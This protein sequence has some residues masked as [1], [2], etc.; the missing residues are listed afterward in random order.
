MC[1]PWPF[2]PL[3]GPEGVGPEGPAWAGQGVTWLCVQP[4]PGL[5]PRAWFAELGP[6]IYHLELVAFGQRSDQRPGAMDSIPDK[7]SALKVMA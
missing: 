1:R 2:A 4:P 7:C 3:C 6:P 5:S